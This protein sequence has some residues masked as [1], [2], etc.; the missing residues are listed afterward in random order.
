MDV[1]EFYSLDVLLK[2]LNQRKGLCIFRGQ[3]PQNRE[4]NSTLGR[5]LRG[6]STKLPR[7]YIPPEPL[8]TW[9]LR[10]LYVYHRTIFRCFQPHES[11]LRRLNGKG[12]P[13]FEVIRYIQQNPDQKKIQNAIPNHPTPTIE[14]SEDIAMALD[15]CSDKSDEDG[16]I[17]CI[18]KHAILTCN[19][20]AEA[21]QAIAQSNDITPCI[22]NP[23]VQL[24]DLDDSKPSRQQAVYIFQRDLRNPIDRHL[25]VEKFLIN[26]TLHNL[27]KTFLAKQGMTKSFLYNIPG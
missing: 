23:L 8:H 21:H 25:P 6:E 27:I 15:I 5:E 7:N 16:A 11:L 10:D 9:T 4:L 17:F 3:S 14:F 19:S 22:I 24:N 18:Q 26:K 2:W 20:F 13:I 12:D 1:F